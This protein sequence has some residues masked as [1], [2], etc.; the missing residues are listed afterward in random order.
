MFKT[1]PA[2]GFDG[3]VQCKVLEI[4]PPERL[5]ISWKGGALD[6][7]VTFELEEAGGQTQLTVSHA[8]FKGLS[9]LIPWVALGLGWKDLLSKTLPTYLRTNQSK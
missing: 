5:K 2:P 1:A 7:V 6:T 3:T 8:N 9:N 4:T